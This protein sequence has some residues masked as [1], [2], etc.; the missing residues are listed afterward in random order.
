MPPANDPQSQIA[1]DSQP[2]DQP[3]DNNHP[4]N[5]STELTT[6]GQ[7]KLKEGLASVIEAHQ[8]D[9]AAARL[10]QYKQVA[11]AVQD[12][13]AAEVAEAAEAAKRVVGATAAVAATP[14]VAATPATVAP[15]PAAAP[16]PAMQSP[17]A[18]PAAPTPPQL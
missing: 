17:Q 1:T 13:N 9:N 5:G 10:A 11:E 3:A 18:M 4:N 12:A 2:F 8:G 6:A 7:P 15:A 16:A 14:S